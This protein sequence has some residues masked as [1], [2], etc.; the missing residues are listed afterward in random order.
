MLMLY[1][2]ENTPTPIPN[3]NLPNSVKEGKSDIKT[4]LLMQLYYFNLFY[5]RVSD[6]LSNCSFKYLSALQLTSEQTYCVTKTTQV[7]VQKLGFINPNSGPV[8]HIK[9]LQFSEILSA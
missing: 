8:N 7:I 4:H 1:R 5:T 3:L 9:N 6:V 2:V